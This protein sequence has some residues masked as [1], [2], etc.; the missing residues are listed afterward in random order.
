MSQPLPT[1]NLD[2]RSDEELLTQTQLRVRNASGGTLTDFAPGGPLAAL[3]EGQVYLTG[4]LLWSLNQLPPAIALE[5]MRYSGIERSQGTKAQGALTFTLE[6]VRS[7]D[8]VLPTGYRIEFS[9][10]GYRLTEPLIIP[11]GFLEATATVEAEEAGTL[12]NLPAR[13][14]S[15]TRLAGLDTIVNQEAISGGTEPESLGRT[16]QRCQEFIRSKGAIVTPGQYREATLDYLGEGSSAVV[17]PLLAEDRERSITGHVHVV[18][19]DSTGDP[20]SGPLLEALREELT[21]RA[22]A[23]SYTHVSNPDLLPLK[24]VIAARV[25]EID[26]DLTGEVWAFLLE[27]LKPGNY[28]IG[29]DLLLSDIQFDIRTAF[30][31]VRVTSLAGN[32]QTVGVAYGRFSYPYLESLTLTQSTDDD[33]LTEVLGRDLGDRF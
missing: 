28:P 21:S 1:I 24:L 13:Q 33:S 22:I 4:A 23:G 17:F 9:R 2:P 29:Q 15:S 26:P 16:L 19:T 10:L 12:H 11:S 32:D 27:A 31:G 7:R 20:L 18:A 8:Y 5:V 3:T 30:P 14:F 25:E 6:A